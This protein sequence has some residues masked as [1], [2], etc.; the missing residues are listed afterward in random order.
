MSALQLCD[1]LAILRLPGVDRR[2]RQD[3]PARVLRP[4]TVARQ[5]GE[6]RHVHQYHNLFV[7]M[8]QVGD[9]LVES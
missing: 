2:T 6:F 1:D 9:G 5:E 7:G 8:L 3:A 4:L